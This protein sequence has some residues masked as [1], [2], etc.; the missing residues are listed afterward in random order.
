[1]G[2]FEIVG[3]FVV[4]GLI[5]FLLLFIV[6][7]IAIKPKEAFIEPKNMPKLTPIPIPTKNRSFFKR[8]LVWF[9]D[10]R[11]W[12]LAQNW[13]FKIKDDTEIVIPKGFRFDG[14]SVPRPLWAIM[15][16]TGLLLIPGLIHDYGYKYNQLWKR[17][18][19]SKIVAYMNKAGKSYWDK[20]FLEVGEQV[21]GFALIG[22]IAF[23]GIVLGGS[24]ARK[25][26]PQKGRKSRYP[27]ILNSSGY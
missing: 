10:V 19:D 7:L 8:I 2:F 23:L 11:K 14:A 21:N 9:F 25:K 6:Y 3:V 24:W 27:K 16:P 22:R 15:S 12:E 20:L 13:L 26:P 18:S 5:F 1:M 4:L 17:E